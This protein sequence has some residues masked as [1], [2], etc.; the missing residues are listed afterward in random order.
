M[1]VLVTGATG[2]IGGRLVPELLAA[3]HEV[4]CGA[5]SPE[6]L[7]DRPWRDDVE[8]VPLD[9]TDPDVTRRAVEGVDVV[10]HLVHAMDGKADF[11]ARDRQAAANVRDACAEA[12]VQRIVYLGGLGDPDDDLSEHLRSRHEVG[13]VLAAGTVPVTELRAAIIIGSGSASFEMLRNLTDVLPAMVTPRWVDTRCQPIAVRDVLA[14]LVAVLDHDETAGRIIEI[15]GSDVMTYREMMATY[16]EVAGLRPR[17]I[18]PVP[19]LTPRL[20]SLWVG[21]VTPLPAGL[22]R[23]LIDSLVN[24]VVVSEERAAPQLLE[25]EPLSFVEAVRLALQRIQD[26]EVVTTWAGARWRADRTGPRPV[27]QRPAAAQ[28]SGGVQPLPEDPHPEDPAWSGGTVLSD[29]R[30]VTSAVAPEALWAAVCRLGGEQG[31]HTPRLLWSVRGLLD[32]LV[33]GIG[34]R[35]GRRHP[36]RLAVGDPVDFWRVERLEEG[37]LLRLRAEMRLPGEAWLDLRVEP[38]P[39]GS[40]LVQ[41][42]RFHP[43]GVVGRAYWYALAPFHR[44]IF[45]RMARGI[46]RA[47][48]RHG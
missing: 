22:A 23:P 8:V 34:V 46:V 1:R 17:L 6:R 5:R 45:P 11:A 9:V 43:R 21:L 41:R 26:L 13:Q 33:G 15:G 35:R 20:S 42:A 32:E 14:Y 37:R 3:G 24:E 44:L 7:G 10:Y 18:V 38:H 31:W 27:G 29:E 16:A 28:R 48:A 40:R 47:A 39:R 4:R 2:Y 12:G 25:R 36:H 19:V 30:S